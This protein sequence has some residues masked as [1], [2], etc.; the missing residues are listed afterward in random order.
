MYLTKV[1]DN[2]SLLAYHHEI[3][4]TGAKTTQVDRKMVN[5]TSAH[6]Q[7]LSRQRERAIAFV[8]MAK[9]YDLPEDVINDYAKSVQILSREP[10]D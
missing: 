1:Q 4:T 8:D 2:L 3:Y 10:S 7:Y 5:T 6:A 9:I